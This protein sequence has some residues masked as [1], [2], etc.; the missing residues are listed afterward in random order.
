VRFALA[1]VVLL[2]AAC[3]TPDRA[4]PWDLNEITQSVLLSAFNRP[5]DDVRVLAW[6][7]EGY[8]SPPV[9]KW[10]CA[11][12]WIDLKSDDSQPS[13]ALVRVIRSTAAGWLW[14]LD[15]SP[16]GSPAILPLKR[17]PTSKEIELFAHG[18][19]GPARAGA[20]LYDS[21]ILAHNWKEV[22]GQ[23]PTTRYR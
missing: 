8:E 13:Y 2:V 1:V 20:K 22:T 14:E 5:V 9:V 18:W 3:G 6:H 12:L 7:A 4:P 11:L 10:Q 23:S 21:E 19:F 17:A 15:Q 16:H